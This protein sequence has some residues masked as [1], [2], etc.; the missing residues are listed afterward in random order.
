MSEPVNAPTLVAQ[1]LSAR[2]DL[3]G[4]AGLARRLRRRWLLGLAAWTIAAVALSFSPIG[5]ELNPS[6]SLTGLLVGC[7]VGL[8]GIGGGALL[9]PIL[10]FFFGFQ[11]SLAIGTDIAYAAITKGFGSWRHL[12]QGSVDKPLAVWLAVG[13]VPAGIL[14]A[15]AVDL[16]GAQQG[17]ALDAI[18]YRAVGG[19][20][21]LVAIL[22]VVKL[23]L[24]PGKALVIENIP[25]STTRKMATVGIGATAGL[26][27]G[28]TS[29]G[30]GS[31]IAL[32][33]IL[34]Y[35]LGAR[36]VVGT[37]IFHATILLAVT[38][39]AQLRF[40]NVDLWVVAALLLGSVPG[41]IMGSHLTKYAPTR[42]L[43]IAL[44]TVLFLSG[45][46]LLGKG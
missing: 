31:V 5:R 10:I 21:T 30:S 35:P 7:L 9:T 23:L 43:F 29:V 6:L 19:A 22:L 12:S 13:S 28:F 36:R 8:T 18:L 2:V 26:L 1:D 24:K 39:L 32:I 11:P 4:S 37:D 20:L 33:L 44:A 27:I 15:M 25:M 46:A 45:L 16:I 17:A 34:F 38:A 41:V 3:P 40:G 42:L 14:G